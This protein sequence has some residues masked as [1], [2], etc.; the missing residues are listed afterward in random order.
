MTALDYLEY[1]KNK[2]LNT[3]EIWEIICKLWPS[4]KKEGR[5]QGL[6]D[7]SVITEERFIY[8]AAHQ[9]IDDHFL[10]CWYCFAFDKFNHNVEDVIYHASNV[11][12]IKHVLTAEEVKKRT[13]N[14]LT[15]LVNSL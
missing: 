2:T 13:K 6:V 11:A 3:S 9:M 4:C 8:V 5:E 12:D 10:R 7:V 14:Y 1:K 15:Y